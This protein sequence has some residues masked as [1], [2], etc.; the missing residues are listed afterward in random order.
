[1][2]TFIVCAVVA[3]ALFFACRYLY[4]QKKRGK[5]ASCPYCEGCNRTCD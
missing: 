4:K 5:C 2:G 1:M 3:T